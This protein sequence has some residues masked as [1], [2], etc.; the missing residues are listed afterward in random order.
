MINAFVAVTDYEW[1]RRLSASPQ[2]DEV[3]FWRPGG[4]A[5]FRAL[6]AG[7]PFLIKLKAPREFH[8]GRCILRALHATSLHTRVGRVPREKRHAHVRG[9]SR[10]DT[11]AE[12]RPAVAGGLHHRL[13][14]TR[15]TILFFREG[16]DTLAVGIQA[17]HGTRTHVR[18]HCRRWAPS[19]GRGAAATGNA[20]VLQA[21]SDANGRGFGSQVWRANH[22]TPAARTRIVSS[23]G[24]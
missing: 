16:L 8:R 13:Y 1:Y 20:Q 19:V 21:I 10:E 4:K 22:H 14:S 23:N 9:V 15:A 17:E 2:I 6:A 12:A 24:H 5:A 11:G 3:N 7:E 18:P